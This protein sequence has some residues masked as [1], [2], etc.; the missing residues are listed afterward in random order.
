MMS[1]TE[2]IDWLAEHGFG[3]WYAK[4]GRGRGAWASLGGT[5]FATPREAIDALISRWNQMRGVK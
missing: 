5:G 3:V 1:D 4:D 2:R